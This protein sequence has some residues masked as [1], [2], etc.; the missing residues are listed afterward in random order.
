MSKKLKAYMRTAG[1]CTSGSYDAS[2]NVIRGVYV[3]GSD[4]SDRIRTDSRCALSETVPVLFYLFF[5][6]CITD[7]GIDQYSDHDRVIFADRSSV[8]SVFS[9]FPGGVCKAW[10]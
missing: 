1:I 10:K 7:A 2:G 8:W 3:C 5:G 9:N 6:K 4:L